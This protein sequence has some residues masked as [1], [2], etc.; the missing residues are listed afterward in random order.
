MTLQVH[1]VDSQQQ[2]ERRGIINLLSDALIASIFD[3]RLGI[4]NM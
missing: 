4:W 3:Y 1:A 2:S